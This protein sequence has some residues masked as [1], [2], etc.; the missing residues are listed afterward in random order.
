MRHIGDY[1]HARIQ[2]VWVT[3]VIAVVLALPTVFIG[4]IPILW[5]FYAACT[6]GGPRL[7]VIDKPAFEQALP[8]PWSVLIG[9]IGTFI[10]PPW[11]LVIVFLVMFL[12][13]H[14]ESL[15]RRILYKLPGFGWNK[16][17]VVDTLLT[18][19]PFSPIVVLW[20]MKGYFQ[21]PWWL[22]SV[23]LGGVAVGGLSIVFV[24]FYGLLGIISAVFGERIYRLHLPSQLPWTLAAALSELSSMPEMDSSVNAATENGNL[25][26]FMEN[27]K[28]LWSEC[29]DALQSRNEERDRLVD[30]AI[31]K[32]PIIKK[33]LANG[34][35]PIC[36]RTD[37]TAD[38]NPSPYARAIKGRLPLR[39]AVYDQMLVV[40]VSLDKLEQSLTLRKQMSADVLVENAR[41][42]KDAL[43]HLELIVYSSGSFFTSCAV[44]PEVDLHF[45]NPSGRDRILYHLEDAAKAMA[46]IPSI[47]ATADRAQAD[48]VGR[49][50]SERAEAIRDLKTWVML[51]LDCSRRDLDTKLRQLL[52]LIAQG[53]WGALDR[54]EVP[55]VPV[56]PWWHR[57]LEMGRKCLI[58]LL[59]LS[60]FFVMKWLNLKVPAEVETWVLS[61]VCGWT[62]VSLLAL[63]DPGFAEKLS[64]IKDVR[65]KLSL[66]SK[67]GPAK[68]DKKREQ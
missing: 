22:E 39:L 29:H 46:A 59:P 24:L 4:S 17:F 58:A 45:Q 6:I 9:P 37:D 68:Y 26:A 33:Q 64:S 38:L 57:A 25:L 14:L 30:L 67:E 43:E 3:T 32:I 53:N 49:V 19:A 1:A 18:V 52:L 44:V 15:V 41:V 51:P 35:N 5:I 34:L 60:I 40:G 2:K 42:Y 47:L 36:M 62:V 23:A 28:L 54:R 63:L 66:G 13:N 50:Y 8:G 48:W 31:K 20:L 56:L 16:L 27:A 10:P 12:L 21:P 7:F 65:E 61:L 55:T 11:P